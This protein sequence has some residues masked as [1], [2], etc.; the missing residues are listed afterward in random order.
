MVTHQQLQRAG[1]GTDRGDLYGA[2]PVPDDAMLDGVL[3]QLR[4]HHRQRC[5]HLGRQHTERARTTQLHRP[6]CDVEHHR[7]D[8]VGDGVEVDGLVER[9]GQG[10]VDDRDG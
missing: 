5:R 2:R 3:Q 8:A 6:P 7:R 10:L 4:Q 1:L 9:P